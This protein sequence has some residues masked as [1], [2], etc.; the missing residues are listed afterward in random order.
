MV[1]DKGKNSFD[2]LEDAVEYFEKIYVNLPKVVIRDA[3]EYCQ[4]NPE[5]YPEGWKD[6]NLRKIPKP[7]KPIEK[8][9]EGAVEIFDVPDDPRVKMIKHKEG[10]TLL[11]A[12]EAM[13]LQVKINEALAKQ[14]ADGEAKKKREAL[15]EKFRMAKER[16]AH[17]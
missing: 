16:V 12:E 11:T 17:K 7:K 3:I 15:D 2:C 9:I 5:K 4:S 1:L 8:V 6:I 10:A 13:E 14:E